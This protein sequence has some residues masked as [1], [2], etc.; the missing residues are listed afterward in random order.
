MAALD[1]NQSLSGSDL[2]NWRSDSPTRES[3]DGSTF[4]SCTHPDA[5]FHLPT[6]QSRQ[7]LLA[8]NAKVIRFR[9]KVDLVRNVQNC[10][11]SKNAVD[12]VQQIGEVGD[13][14]HAMTNDDIRPIG[15]GL[16]PL[17]NRPEYL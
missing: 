17:E 13:V 4:Y 2:S 6:R 9:E 7:F 12:H 10:L 11:T 14:L 15:H 3:S 8:E 1:R 16:S 5:Q